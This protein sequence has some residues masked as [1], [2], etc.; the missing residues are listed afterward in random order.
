MQFP[1]ESSRMTLDSHATPKTRLASDTEIG[2][3]RIVLSG[4]SLR[5]YQLGTTSGFEGTIL[6]LLSELSSPLEEYPWNWK[7]GYC[8][9][10]EQA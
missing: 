2:I 6:A 1:A 9:E 3:W 7:H 8:D 10:A 4:S 5:L